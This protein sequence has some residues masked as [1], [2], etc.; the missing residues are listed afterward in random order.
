VV[1][2]D[3]EA[4]IERTLAIIRAERCQSERLTDKPNKEN[5]IDRSVIRKKGRRAEDRD[6]RAQAERMNALRIASGTGA[7]DAKVTIEA[8]RRA[9]QGESWRIATESE[10]KEERRES[11]RKKEDFS[12]GD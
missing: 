9:E 1:N 5:Q 4:A 10:T 8:M 12:F 11:A 7:G 6:R 3:L 2:D